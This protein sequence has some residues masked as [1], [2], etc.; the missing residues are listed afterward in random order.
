MRNL[1]MVRR[2]VTVRFL[3]RGRAIITCATSN[4]IGIVLIR[5]KPQSLIFPRFGYAQRPG[6]TI[7]RKAI[8]ITTF[9]VRTEVITLGLLLI[10]VGFFY[11]HAALPLGEGGLGGI[12]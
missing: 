9:N 7:R 2:N 8:V 10:V 12:D 1:L 11:P 5:V 6:K 3:S 4:Q